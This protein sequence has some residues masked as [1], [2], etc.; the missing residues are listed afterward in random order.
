MTVREN[1]GPRLP[2]C[3]YRPRRAENLEGIRA[4]AAGRA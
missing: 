4:I 2:F 3:P 1:L